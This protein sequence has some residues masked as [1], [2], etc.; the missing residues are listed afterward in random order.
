[1]EGRQLGLWEKPVISDE[2]FFLDDSEELYP[3]DE[4]ARENVFF[5]DVP[6][7]I[8]EAIEKEAPDEEKEIPFLDEGSSYEKDYIPGI[9]AKKS[10]N[11]KELSALLWLSKEIKVK[12]DD[13]ARVLI[14][15][16]EGSA[17]R[18]SFIYKAN[19]KNRLICMPDKTLKTVQRHINRYILQYCN[20]LTNVSG[21]SGGN[22]E[23]AIK[24]HLQSKILISVDLVDAF[25]TITSDNLISYFTQGRKVLIN[26]S[27]EVKIKEYGWFSWYAARILTELMTER[28]RLPQGAPTSPRIF[29]AVCEGLD[30][31][32]LRLAEK[33]GGTYTR[34][35]DNIFISI[36]KEKFQWEITQ[37]MCGLIRGNWG[38]DNRKP[39][40]PTFKYHKLRAREINDIPQRVLGLNII[41]GKIHNTR[42][43]KRRL[44]LSIYHINWL[45]DRGMQDTPEF[46]TAWRKLQGQMAFAR[47]DTLPKKLLDAYSKL[48]KR[49]N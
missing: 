46:E 1:M 21:F 34:Y 29:D 26:G 8:L 24:P 35:A 22:I 11:N 16:R 18:F 43:F 7:A 27:G 48:E 4:Y 45:L 49:L 41:E 17:Y 3:I 19:G 40:D 10:K 15:V 9:P 12:C 5:E 20:T 23:N 36:N 42:C 6:M 33:F 28:K 13:L 44:R 38:F 25:P 47:I 32:L 30:R 14:L 2:D 37:I 31:Q 39:F